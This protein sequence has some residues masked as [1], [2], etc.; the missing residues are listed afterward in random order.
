MH[1]CDFENNAG[2]SYK[3]RVLAAIAEILVFFVMLDKGGSDEGSGEEGS[4]DASGESSG[5]YNTGDVNKH[6]LFF[7]HFIKILAYRFALILFN[8]LHIP[9]VGCQDNY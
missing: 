9:Y 3:T 4:G 1:F 8:L 5:E 7:L 2:R 6:F